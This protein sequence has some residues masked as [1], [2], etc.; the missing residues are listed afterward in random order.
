[1]N[2]CCQAVSL[3]SNDFYG[4]AHQLGK[5]RLVALDISVEQQVEIVLAVRC[6]QVFSR[7]CVT[8]AAHL[9]CRLLTVC[10]EDADRGA[11]QGSS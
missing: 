5:C 2:D 3:Q 9:R 10:V 1:M 6:V 4:P 8:V 7:R 11:V